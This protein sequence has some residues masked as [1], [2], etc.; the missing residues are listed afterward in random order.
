LIKLGD[1]IGVA[2]TDDTTEFIAR[3]LN[4]LCFAPPCLLPV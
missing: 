1:L 2:G 3:M 4:S